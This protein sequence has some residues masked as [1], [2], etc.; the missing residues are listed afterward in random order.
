LLLVLPAPLLADT[1]Y[2]YTGNTFTSATAPF[3]TSDSV[4][5]SF[6]VA[7]PLGANLPLGAISATAF[8]F[9]DG[10]NT[11]SDT[12]SSV[13]S[14][15]SIETDASGAVTSWL[16][17]LQVPGVMSITTV[18]EFGVAVEDLGGIGEDLSGLPLFGGSNEGD[19]STW[20]MTTTE[21]PS[22]SAVPEPSSL[23]LLG[24]GVLG[25]FCTL[26]RRFLN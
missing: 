18:N 11:L 12:T 25:A 19:P 23:A 3:T 24:T 22:P 9:S 21:D 26:R 1:V 2:T 7:S 16:I 5:G 14:D 17:V 4:T 10:I 15:F 13:V 6:T 8:S 20:T